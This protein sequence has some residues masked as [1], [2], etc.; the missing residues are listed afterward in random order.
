ME[1]VRRKDEELASLASKLSN[2]SVTDAPPTSLRSR[3]DWRRRRR[4]LEEKETALA[5]ATRE[6]AA[7]RAELTALAVHQERLAK[8]ADHARA[9]AERA[10]A[11]AKEG[12][13]SSCRRRGGFGGGTR[14]LRRRARRRRLAR[15]INARSQ[16]DV[17]E[18]IARERDAKEDLVELRVSHERL[19]QEFRDKT[20]NAL[21]KL[22]AAERTL[23][24]ERHKSE[25]RDTSNRDRIAQ[26]ERVRVDAEHETRRLRE[27]LE[28]QKQETYHLYANHAN[29][30]NQLEDAKTGARTRTRGVH[31]HAQ[32][33]RRAEDATRGRCGRGRRR[34]GSR[35]GIRGGAA[36]IETGIRRI[37][38]AGHRGAADEV[39]WG[40]RGAGGITVARVAHAVAR[41]GEGA[42][43]G[44]RGV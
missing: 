8:D 12:S 34:G 44:H 4:R 17:A 11:S 15:D 9:E 37:P 28:R 33:I 6:L 42:S 36:A 31:P 13:A 2:G 20:A 19:Q 14:R 32:G 10:R 27:A 38:S 41:G 22:A 5:D 35:A 39:A 40:N 29:V 25:T 18:W 16:T 43:R 7:M 1:L 23:L 24:E 21:E 3:P 26:L 30:A